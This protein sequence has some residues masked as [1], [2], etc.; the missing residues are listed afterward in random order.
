MVESTIVEAWLYSTLSGSATLK[1]YVDT[2]IYSHVAPAGAATPFVLWSHQSSH[3]VRGVGPTRVMA[4]YVYQVKVV[5]Q[6]GGFGGIADAADEL[7]DLLQGAT[8]T[9]TDG[10]VLSCV[11][12]STVAYAEVENG[13][14]YRH[15]GGLY[16]IFAQET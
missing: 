13:V 2:R 15:L 9:T 12:E 1:T 14:Q 5:G 11:R 7:D 16:R 8:G 6:T 10:I 4:S 3:D